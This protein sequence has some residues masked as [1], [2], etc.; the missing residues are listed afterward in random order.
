M[1]YDGTS[2]LYTAPDD[3]SQD[4]LC[5][6]QLPLNE[7][8]STLPSHPSPGGS[9]AIDLS[10]SW[11]LSI[12]PNTNPREPV[13][14]KNT[15][16]PIVAVLIFFLLL[17]QR[18]AGDVKPQTSA[19]SFAVCSRAAVKERSPP[20]THAATSLKEVKW[21]RCLRVCGGFIARVSDVLPA[22]L[23]PPLAG[24]LCQRRNPMPT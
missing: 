9:D 17:S 16:D 8:G 11:T 21:L 2:G 5:L 24:L 14:K 18:A 13:K 4:P 15:W 1:L 22:A 20:R 12:P 19:V 7:L 6:S 23:I 3:S 10:G